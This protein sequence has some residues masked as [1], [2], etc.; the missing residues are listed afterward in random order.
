M[1][2]IVVDTSVILE[3]LYNIDLLLQEH[4]VFLT[5]IVLQ[6]LDGKKNDEKVGYNSREFY[7]ILGHS[8]TLKLSKL[9]NSDIVAF[10][11]DS[12]IQMAYK[13][14]YIYM[15]VRNYYKLRDINDSKII[16]IAKDY[17]MTLVTMDMAQKVR[18]ATQDVVA[19]I[20][21]KEDYIIKHVPQQ[22]EQKQPI[23]QEVPKK[24][25]IDPHT[26]SAI[27]IMK[28]RLELQNSK[29]WYKFW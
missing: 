11:N 8:T 27:D 26:Q 14:K 18:A 16:E 4:N 2:N 12:I 23:V 3:S 25:A 29:P 5:D 6:E 28:Q 9:P 15:I 20:F 17:E 24:Y 7:R 10:N 1:K 22:L 13:N 19:N 21:H